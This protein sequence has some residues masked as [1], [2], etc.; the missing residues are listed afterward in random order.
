M[1]VRR[2]STTWILICDGARAHIVANGGP[3]TGLTG[4]SRAS[5][6]AAKIPT[7]DLGTD[8]P[9]RVVES[10][11]S[12]RH[13][14][15]PP[16]DWHRFEKQ[17]FAREMAALVNRAALEKRFDRLV[18]VAPPMTLGDLRKALDPHASRL[19]AGELAKDLTG[20]EIHELESH[21]REFLNS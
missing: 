2:K 9:G 13:A 12:G 19:V 18:I 10:V 16:I 4:V 17:K 5:H 20:L 1:I 11:G 15:S 7:R 8:R 3:G 14:M 21:L 6:R